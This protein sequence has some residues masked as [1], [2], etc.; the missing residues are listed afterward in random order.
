MAIV[1]DVLL[2]IEEKQWDLPYH[3]GCYFRITFKN[4]ILK[5]FEQKMTSLYKITQVHLY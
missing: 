2:K 1:L 4:N 5:T 3:F